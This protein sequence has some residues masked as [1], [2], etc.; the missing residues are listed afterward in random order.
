[1][2]RPNKFF[3][4]KNAVPRLPLRLPRQVES[5]SWRFVCQPDHRGRQ[6]PCRQQHQR[7]VWQEMA[8]VDDLSWSRYRHQNQSAVIRVN[9]ASMASLVFSA[10]GVTARKMIL[11]P[12]LKLLP[13]CSSSDPPERLERSLRFSWKRKFPPKEAL[14]GSR[15]TANYL[16]PA[17]QKRARELE[18]TGFLQMTLAANEQNRLDWRLR[19]RWIS[20]QKVG[21]ENSPSPTVS[22][23]FKM[24]VL[25]IINWDVQGLVEK[26]GRGYSDPL[27]GAGI[28]K[29]GNL[30]RPWQRRHGPLHELH[31]QL[32]V[33]WSGAWPKYGHKCG[34]LP[35]GRSRMEPANRGLW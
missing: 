30:R 21:S 10:V 3:G 7:S 8:K 22:G 29:K 5:C 24:K 28:L 1:M 11:M 33:C 12:S 25:N 2:F 13:T 16:T 6:E 18:A 27:D 35:D 20:K 4:A 15:F 32:S 14:A 23:K 19:H 9:A 17:P 26:L 34:R 31:G